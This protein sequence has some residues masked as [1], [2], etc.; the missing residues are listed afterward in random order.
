M[1]LFDCKCILQE[2]YYWLIYLVALVL[3]QTWDLSSLICEFWSMNLAKVVVDSKALPCAGE[4]DHFKALCSQFGGTGL[5]IVNVLSISLCHVLSL[6]AWVI[7]TT[8]SS[9]HLVSIWLGLHLLLLLRP[10]TFDIFPSVILL[11]GLCLNNMSILTFIKWGLINL[12]EIVAGD[13]GHSVS[14][15]ISIS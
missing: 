5:T 6:S 13:L 7:W 3:W 4:L 11:W 9:V 14:H 15:G 12:V 2:F 1:N 8:P 10:W